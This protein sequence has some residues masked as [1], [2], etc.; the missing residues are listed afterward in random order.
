MICA[1]SS[2]DRV[3]PARRTLATPAASA[4]SRDSSAGPVGRFSDEGRPTYDVEYK[5]DNRWSV[6]GEYDRFGDFNAGFKWRV[7]SK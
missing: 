7:Y 6:T 4:P 3:E 5:L 2:R 1:P